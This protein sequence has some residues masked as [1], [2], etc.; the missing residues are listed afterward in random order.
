[1][2]LSPAMIVVLLLI[3]SDVGCSLD[4]DS[5]GLPFLRANGA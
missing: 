2:I 5:T 1:M 3:Q 4:G